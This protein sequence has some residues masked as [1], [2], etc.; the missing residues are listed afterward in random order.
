[1]KL[2]SYLYGSKQAPVMFQKLLKEVLIYAGYRICDQDDCVFVRHVRSDFSI[3]AV[4]VDDILQVA[5]SDDLV[6]DLHNKLIERFKDVVYH[7]EVKNYLGLNIV[8]SEDGTKIKVNHLGKINELCSKYLP[9]DA[10]SMNYPSKED[11]FH[12]HDS[13]RLDE[14][15]NKVYLS[16]VMSLLYIARLT[17]PDTLLPSAFLAS[18]AHLATVQDLRKLMQYVNP[19]RSPISYMSYPREFTF[20]SICIVGQMASFS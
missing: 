6:S 2:D 4:H 16:I 7:S 17:R 19:T 20:I 14:A 8:R 18:R 11:L 9:S 13:E 15:T 5:T 10:K 3:L 12:V 1:L